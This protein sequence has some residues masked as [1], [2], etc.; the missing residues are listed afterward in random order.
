MFFISVRIAKTSTNPVLFMNFLEKFRLD[1]YL[2]QHFMCRKVRREKFKFLSL[3][4]RF[5]EILRFSQNGRKNSLITSYISGGK[6]YLTLV[7][8]FINLNITYLF[9]P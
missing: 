7:H 8:K 1:V 5:Q 3:C 2:K 6:L 9:W 4:V